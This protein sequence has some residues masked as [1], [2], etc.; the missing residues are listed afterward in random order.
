MPQRSCG[1]AVDF[2]QAL[3]AY[4]F[5]LADGRDDTA[6]FLQHVV[7]D[8]GIRRQHL[9]NGGE[10]ALLVKDKSEQLLAKHSLE[11]LQAEALTLPGA[12]PS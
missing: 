1:K 11:F 10:S 6:D 7:T 2:R 12:D 8:G 3:R 9:R 4:A 5:R